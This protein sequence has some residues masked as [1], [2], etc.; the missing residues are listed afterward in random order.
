[1][2]SVRPIDHKDHTDVSMTPDNCVEDFDIATLRHCHSDRLSCSVTRTG[3]RTRSEQRCVQQNNKQNEL[4]WPINTS[5]FPNMLGHFEIHFE[6]H[7]E[8]VC[9]RCIIHHLISV[10]LGFYIFGDSC[11]KPFDTSTVSLQTVWKGFSNFGEK[12]PRDSP[13]NARSNKS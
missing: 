3:I 2:F 7:F 4:N 10:C 8:N 6:V 13:G 9:I 1:M 11:S 5:L 12:V